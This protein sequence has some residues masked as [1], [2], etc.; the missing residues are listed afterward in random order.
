MIENESFNE[1]LAALTV[2]QRAVLDLVL[3]HKS[4]KEIA[5]ALCISPYTV[6]QRIHAVRQK[7]GV[8][9]RG[10]VARIYAR[11]K[12]VCGETAYEFPYVDF[13][14][15]SVESGN[16]DARSD[17]ILTLSDVAVIDYPAPWQS[18]SFR[19]GGLE[20]LDNR[21]GIFGRVFAVFALAGMIAMVMLVMVSIAETLSTLV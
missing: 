11:Y 16:R 12:S 2:K 20:A 15:N 21:F 19:V 3:E 9:S 1:A 17:P 4:S 14:Q 10:E 6:D 5:R 18:G 8:S 13:S 7:F